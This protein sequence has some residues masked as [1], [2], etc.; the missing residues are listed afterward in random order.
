M[1]LLLGLIYFLHYKY[2]QT[3]VFNLKAPALLYVFL[4][5]AL[6]ALRFEARFV[7]FAGLTAAAGW[8]A[9]IFYALSG[10][11]GPPN[12]T[13]DFVEYMTSN[14]FLIQ[15]EVEKLLAI[16]LTTAVLAIA[17]SRARHLLVQSVS[18]G[19]AARD[20]ARFF[21]P[22][23]ADR[24]RSAA[25]SIK[26]GEGELR[27]V[28]ILTVDL[29]GFTRL[30]GRAAARRGHEAPAGLSGTGLPLDRQQ[31]RQHRQVPGRRHSCLVRRRG[32]LDHRGGRRLARRR[33]R[34]RRRRSL[35]RRAPGG[36]PVAALRSDWLWRPVASSSARWAMA[37]G[38][39]S[40]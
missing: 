15:A 16:L 24:I 32:G 3:A 29:R 1:A 10:R 35:G 11:G 40:P 38:W 20:L 14:A 23:V 37:S 7:I 17:I 18:E 19:A 5:I 12:E 8:L 6:R 27:D 9:L 26:A 4:F 34:A 22:G 25:M 21:D 33:C 2:A 31:R 30:A 28:A 39:N 36:R 13:T